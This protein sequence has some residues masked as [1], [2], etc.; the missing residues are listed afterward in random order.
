MLWRF[1]SCTRCRKESDD[2][3]LILEQRV[4]EL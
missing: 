2:L 4:Q 3:D 1:K